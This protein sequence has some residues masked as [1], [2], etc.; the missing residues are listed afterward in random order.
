MGETFGAT[1]DFAVEIGVGR[2]VVLFV[3]ALSAAAFGLD[4]ALLLPFNFVPSE[5]LETS[6]VFFGSFFEFSTLGTSFDRAGIFS[7]FAVFGVSTSGIE[8]SITAL[9]FF[10]L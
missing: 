9:L 3:G 1:A 2:L 10:L 6:P 7:S 4:V 5:L 8:S